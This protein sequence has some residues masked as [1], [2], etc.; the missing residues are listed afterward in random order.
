MSESPEQNIQVDE[1]QAPVG[2]PDVSDLQNQIE[3]LKANNQKLLSEKKNATASQEDL[4]RQIK[5]LQNNQQKA[6]QS[7]LAEAGEFKTLW[8]EATGTV[9]SLQ[10]QIAELKQQLQDKD[11]AFQQSQIKSAALNA[12][13]QSGVHS[14]EHMFTL[15]KDNLRMK[16]GNLV[17]LHG[18]VEVQLNDHL[19]S[20]KSPGSGMDYF[21]AGS[22]ARGMSAAGSSSSTAGG[23]SWS[24]M[25]V[26]ERIQLEMDNPQRAQQLKA[27]G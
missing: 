22:G 2:G 3:L 13:S 6:K 27:A 17:A 10:D 21:F 23:K 1:A 4:Q 9:S 14:P 8:Q 7:Q 19:E 26:T 24:G 12:F 20:L 18:G 15:M 25:T 16:E 11:L 5:D